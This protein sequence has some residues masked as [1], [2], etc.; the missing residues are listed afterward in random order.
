ML[1]STTLWREADGALRLGAA[2]GPEP[3][4]ATLAA[5]A[6][7]A[8]REGGPIVFLL[9][10]FSYAPGAPARR[11]DPHRGVL[12]ASAH[13]CAVSWPRALGFTGATATGGLA[14]AF[15]WPS[16]PG[17]G[18][19][20]PL[21][22]AYRRAGAV[23]DRLAAAMRL[24]A[25]AAPNRPIDLFAHS[26]GAR[27]AYL[28]LRRASTEGWGG[29]IGRVI[30][31]GAAEYRDEAQQ[32]AACCAPAE[33]DGPQVLNVLARANDAYDAALR[34]F[35]PRAPLDAGAQPLGA[36]GLGAAGA[37]GWFDLQIDHPEAQPWLSAEGV[38]PARRRRVSHTEVY[39]R[40]GLAR[41]YRRILD[42]RWSVE[43]LQ[44]R[45]APRDIEARWSALGARRARSS[46]R[47]SGA[48]AMARA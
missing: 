16:L 43:E 31:L 26:L 13:G 41:L 1:V 7:L 37:S 33:A 40:P 9:H 18:R 25:D 39:A 22:A 8:A 15:A 28:A 45:G 32:A 2:T 42:A 38:A 35:G 6:R 10:G 47:Q 24:V 36:A 44:A 23:A 21:S 27:V 46:T 14:I 20:N 4:E 34:I 19:R 5:A 29:R 17:L 30:T 48:E 12:S 11:L 3:I